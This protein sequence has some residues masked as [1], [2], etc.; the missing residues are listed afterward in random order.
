MNCISLS[1]WIWYLVLSIFLVA[2]LAL[3]K[4]T[5]GMIIMPTN[6]VHVAASAPVQKSAVERSSSDVPQFT[7]NIDWSNVTIHSGGSGDTTQPKA[8]LLIVGL[9]AVVV[10]AIVIYGIW[11]LANKIPNP[12]PTTPPKPPLTNGP[13][14]AFVSGSGMT[15]ADAGSVK[16]SQDLNPVIDMSKN[17]VLWCTDVSDKGWADYYEGHYV[18][19]TTHYFTNVF[20]ISLQS[21][22]DLKTWKNKINF[23][24]YESSS[25]GILQAGFTNNV[26]IYTVYY[27]SEGSMNGL[28]YG[29]AAQLEPKEREFYR[30][31]APTNYPDADLVP[32]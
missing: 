22:E 12:Q 14:V 25:G 8:W 11:T 9:I 3:P 7:E 31:M 1:K 19:N 2:W 24:Y 10:L 20:Y 18:T 21:S 13:P 6:I 17:F 4:A 15:I 26:P 30:L 28:H 32:K 23:V 5:H 29:R 16:S 27:R